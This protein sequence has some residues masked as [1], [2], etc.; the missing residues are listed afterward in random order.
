MSCSSLTC[1]TLSFAQVGIFLVF[2]LPRLVSIH[3]H[4]SSKRWGCWH[5]DSGWDTEGKGRWRV[6]C[7]HHGKM[8]VLNVWYQLC[9]FLFSSLHWHCAFYPY[10]SYQTFKDHWSDFYVQFSILRVLLSFYISRVVHLVK[11]VNKQPHYVLLWIKHFYRIKKKSW[12]NF[13]DI[14]FDNVYKSIKHIP[15]LACVLNYW[16]PPVLW[17]RSLHSHKLIIL[18]LYVHISMYT[19][20]HFRVDNTTP[21]DL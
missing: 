2:V 7:L 15:T 12:P 17:W 14:I 18:T 19:R 3:W 5:K 10:I 1:S 6:R 13:H 11:Y 16:A 9:L 21:S 4:H 20:I 8:V